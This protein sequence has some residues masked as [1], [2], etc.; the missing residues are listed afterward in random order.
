MPLSD[1]ISAASGQSPLRPRSTRL[2]PAQPC[3]RLAAGVPTPARPASAGPAAAE[4][5]ITSPR[6]RSRAR[7]PSGN[8]S[9]RTTVAPRGLATT[10]RCRVSGCTRVFGSTS[11]P[12]R[13]DVPRQ[14]RVR[15]GK[16][17]AGI[18][19]RRDMT[20]GRGG[21]TGLR[22]HRSTRFV[23]GVRQGATI[24]GPIWIT[25]PPSPPA[26][27]IAIRDWAASIGRQR[28]AG[29]AQPRHPASPVQLPGLVPA[30]AG[31]LVD[32]RGPQQ[33]RLV[34]AAQGL[35]RQPGQASELADPHRSHGLLSRPGGCPVGSTARP[36]P[37]A[38]STACSVQPRARRHLAA[39]AAAVRR[40]AVA[41]PWAAGQTGGLQA[42]QLAAADLAGTSHCA[43]G[44]AARRRGPFGLR[45]PRGGGART[46][47]RGGAGHCGAESGRNSGRG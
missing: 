33:P 37:R 14:R 47:A 35:G 30:V 11:H 21:R 36:P 27:A 45:G 40:A 16:G 29:L 3:S 32:A 23:S 34:V 31:I 6:T 22:S 10:S 19:D 15:A 12:R 9:R 13:G 7:P 26:P 46:I 41:A 28:H 20:G 18:G 42:A 1:A 2:L 39:G 24:S 5:G 4:A 25:R 44:T 43:T 8:T 38:R 17:R